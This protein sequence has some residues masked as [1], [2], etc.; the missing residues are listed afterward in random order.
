M[1]GRVF[2]VDVEVVGVATWPRG[3]VKNV[4]ILKCARFSMSAVAVVYEAFACLKE[5]INCLIE[6][7]TQL[8]VPIQ[9]T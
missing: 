1:V 3:D 9:R 7:C 6:T 2:E 8:L 4:L 5:I